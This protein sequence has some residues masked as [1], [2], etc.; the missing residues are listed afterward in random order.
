MPIFVVDASRSM[1]GFVGCNATATEFDVILDRL[2]TDLSIVTVLQFGEPAIGGGN[3]FDEHPLTRAVHCAQFYDRRQNPDYALYRR[4]REDSSRHAFLYVTDGVQSDLGGSSQSPSVA[5]LKRWVQDGR[6]LAILAFHSRF[7]GQ[8]WS[9]QRRQMLGSVSVKDRPFYAFFF[10]QNEV[11]LEHVL[12]RLSQSTLVKATPMRFDSESVRCNARPAQRL[13]KYTWREKPP[14]AMVRLTSRGALEQPLVDYRCELER[15]Y[16]V[17][18]VLPRVSS[19]YR[20]WT[21]AG[22]SNT[23]N[24]S[25]GARFSADSAEQRNGES[26][27]HIRGSLPFDDLTRFG[28]YGIRMTPE[29]GE[30]RS[31]VRDLSSDSDASLDSFSHTYRFSWLIE[32][33]ARVHLSTAKWTPYALT[34]QY[35]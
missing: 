17:G 7:A 26:V 34:I 30:L 21:N 29:P 35:R 16:P 24:G 22:F 14:W 3:A 11:A 13:P 33:L 1:A 20:R 27:V 6:A 8:A 10:A 2:T 32:Q 18:V 25:T 5:E 31:E 4:I 23:A 12:S 28:F 9:E 19:E 15:G